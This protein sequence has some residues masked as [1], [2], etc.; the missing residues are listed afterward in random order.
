M[1]E[2]FCSSCKALKLSF[3]FAPCMVRKWTTSGKASIQ[4]IAC[5]SGKRKAKI[6]QRREFRF[7]R[8]LIR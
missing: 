5:T 4:C 7:G 8:A 3:C 2:L 6:A 1:I